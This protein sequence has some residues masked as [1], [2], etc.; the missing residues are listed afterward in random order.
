MLFWG[1]PL[2]GIGTHSFKPVCLP[3]SKLSISNLSPLF[4][5][6]G[7]YKQLPQTCWP[8]K[9]KKAKIY[10]LTVLE[11]KITLGENVKMNSS[12]PCLWL[13]FYWN[14]Y[15]HLR[16]KVLSALEIKHKEMCSGRQ[17][18]LL[19]M[20]AKILM[21]IEVSCTDRID[22]WIWEEKVRDEMNWEIGTDTY[23]PP[24]VKQTASGK[25]LNSTGS[26]APCS[27]IT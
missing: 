5:F 24:C 8:E 4:I 19:L 25:L 2:E 27:V 26:S 16:N 11:L 7:H 20:K 14:V 17:Q 12:I 15:K 10:S 3:E 9:K 23:T 21:G 13:Y 1:S 6:G 22:L 18:F